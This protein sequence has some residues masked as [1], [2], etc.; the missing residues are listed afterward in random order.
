MP[1]KDSSMLRFDA[2]DLHQLCNKK[3]IIAN[4]AP[5]QRNASD[6]NGSRLIDEENSTKKG[7]LLKELMH[8]LTVIGFG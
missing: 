4:I 5:N 3:Q 2:E 6:D 7:T 1:T 8:E